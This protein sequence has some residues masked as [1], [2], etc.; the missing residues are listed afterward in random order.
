MNFNDFNSL[1]FVVTFLIVSM[2]T[3]IDGLFKLFGYAKYEK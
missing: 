1:I 2:S 3:A